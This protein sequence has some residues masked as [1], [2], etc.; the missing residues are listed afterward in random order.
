MIVCDPVTYCGQWVYLFEAV[1]YGGQCVGLYEAVPSCGQCLVV[2]D[3]VTNFLDWVDL[4]Y[5]VP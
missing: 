1:P 4:C 2:F 5:A 3:A